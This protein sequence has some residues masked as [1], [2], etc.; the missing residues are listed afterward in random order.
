[1]AVAMAAVGGTFDAIGRTLRM[2]YKA[3]VG[4]KIDRYGLQSLKVYFSKHKNRKKI[5]VYV[6][7]T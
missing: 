6:D 2:K 1:M 3:G 7:M 4:R 5:D